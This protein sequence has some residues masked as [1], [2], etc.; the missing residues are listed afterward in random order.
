MDRIRALFEQ[1]LALPPGQQEAFVRAEAGADTAFADDVL[2]LLGLRHADTVDLGAA[3]R[4][5]LDGAAPSIA[6]PT[7]PGSDQVRPTA[8][9]D[10]LRRLREAPR[11]DPQRYP[12]EGDL[13]KGGMGVV[14][15]I[16]DQFLN[17]RLAIKV[18]R[19]RG[20]PQTEADHRR[21]HQLLG[22]FLEEAQVTS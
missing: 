11:L 3:V 14:R 20:E 2:E 19:E 16:H 5:A 4:Q 12:A 8:T 21:A 22:R 10:L 1:A 15:R 18:L 13:G 17:R 6:A 7:E 9:A